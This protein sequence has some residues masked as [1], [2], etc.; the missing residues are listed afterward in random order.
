MAQSNNIRTTRTMGNSYWIVW[1]LC[2][3]E[4]NCYGWIFAGFATEPSIDGSLKL[5]IDIDTRVI[6]KFPLVF[7]V[8]RWPTKKGEP[9]DVLIVLAAPV[10][11]HHLRKWTEILGRGKVKENLL[12]PLSIMP[13]L[14]LPSRTSN[15]PTVKSKTRGTTM[16]ACSTMSGW[17][18]RSRPRVS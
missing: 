3:M 10:H 7:F 13:T 2:Y 17:S 9:R 6:L 1:P 11:H 12:G 15:A 8:C 18:S 4:S 16:I 14:T 5:T